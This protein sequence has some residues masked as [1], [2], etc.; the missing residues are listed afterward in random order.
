MRGRRRWR[1]GEDDAGR[2]LTTRVDA[3]AVRGTRVKTFFP[4]RPEKESGATKVCPGRTD[5]MSHE[6]GAWSASLR[7]PQRRRD[8]GGEDHEEGDARGSE[9]RGGVPRKEGV[10][11]AGVELA[12]RPRFTSNIPGGEGPRQLGG[13]PRR[14]QQDTMGRG[15]RWWQ[16]RHGR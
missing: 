12:W 8:G 2:R 7:G 9:D 5:K 4:R 15:T 10:R 14:S 16:E 11:R 1:R 13:R 6:I 3:G